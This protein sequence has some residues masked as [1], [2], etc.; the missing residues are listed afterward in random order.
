MNLKLDCVSHSATQ[1]IAAYLSEQYHLKFKHHIRVIAQVVFDEMSA[2][3]PQVKNWNFCEL[4]AEQQSFVRSAVEHLLISPKTP[5]MPDLATQEL[6]H[7]QQMILNTIRG[8]LPPVTELFKKDYLLA[9]VWKK[10]PQI[11]KESRELVSQLLLDI[12]QQLKQREPSLSE[13]FHFEMIIGDLLSLYPFL[14][15]EQN[16]TLRVPVFSDGKWQLIDYK[17]DRIPLTPQWMGSPLVAFGLIPQTASAPP[18]LL[19][20]G[21]TYPTDDGFLL[22]LI[23]DINPFASVGNYGFKWGEKTISE[24][25]NKHVAASKVMIYGKSLGGALARQA[26]LR[27]TAQVGRVM[28]FGAPGLFSTEL[29]RYQ[30]LE[31]EKQLPIIDLFCQENDPVTAVDH[32]ADSG[33]HYY[34]VLGKHARWGVF[35]HAD[36]YSTHEESAVLRLDPKKEERCWIHISMTL[37]RMV[38]S[39]LIFPVLI[40]LSGMTIVMTQTLHLLNRQ[41][42]L[43]SSTLPIALQR[44][45][46]LGAINLRRPLEIQRF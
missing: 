34:K 5:W 35:A 27:F 14:S 22:S 44:I 43:L 19:F 32:M 39:I 3:N 26:A 4:N 45:R 10:N 17:V 18:L 38:A 7:F 33:I 46:Q 31:K 24:W 15:P 30:Q 8:N 6:T 13:I 2:R 37:A 23:V 36:M 25:L 11:L 16:E 42:T 40:F 21:T 20:K 1:G 28:A 41:I 12:A 9:V 29:K